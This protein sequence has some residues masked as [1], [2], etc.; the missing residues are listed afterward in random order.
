MVNVCNGSGIPAFIFLMWMLV[1]GVYS[2]LARAKF[3]RVE[4]NYKFRVT[5]ALVLVGFWVG[6]CF[7]YLFTGSLA[8]LFMI[9]LAV[10][11]S[12]CWYSGSQDQKKEGYLGGG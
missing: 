2:F 5:I 1:R 12:M 6:A 3:P 8:Y 4:D 10:G 11:M 7:N 9:L